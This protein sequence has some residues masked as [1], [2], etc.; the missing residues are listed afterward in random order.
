MANDRS[1]SGGRSE[2]IPEV[3]RKMLAVG[4]S[5]FFTTE[6]AL[7]RALGD[8]IPQDW[9]DFASE[10]SERTRQEFSEAVAKELGHVLERVDLAELLGELFEDRAVEITA[11][12]KLLPR[13]GEA[14]KTRVEDVS[15]AFEPGPR[16]PTSR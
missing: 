7:R 14:P 1:D 13:E 2:P 16:E 8:T 4:L 11:K 3:V 12:V 10:Q 6:E 15:I 9:V 5:G